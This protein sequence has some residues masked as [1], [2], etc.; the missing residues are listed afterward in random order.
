MKICMSSILSFL[1]P[2]AG[3]G[4]IIIHH[5]ANGLSRLGHEVYVIY[6]TRKAVRAVV[7]EARYKII[8]ARHFE[9]RSLNMLSVF[10]AFFR[11][12]R[13]AAFS[14]FLG[15]S[16]EALLVNIF[17]KNRK[18]KLLMAYFN[19]HPPRLY[20]PAGLRLLFSKRFFYL[21]RACLALADSVIAISRD[22][23]RRIS[24]N[25]NIPLRK[26]EVVY[27]GVDIEVFSRQA[28]G[29]PAEKGR[30]VTVGRLDDQKGIDVL[31]K[32]VSLVSRGREIT[33][34]IVGDGWM[35][36]RYEKIASELA[37]SDRV[38]FVGRIQQE[39]IPDYLKRASIFVL[40]SRNESFGLVLVEAMASGIPVISTNVGSIPEIVRDG[41][42]GILVEPGDA[43]MLAS[44]IQDLLDDRGKTKRFTEQARQRVLEN[45]TWEKSVERLDAVYKRN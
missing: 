8:W 6:T 26:I 30:L 44:A 12:R 24:E 17:F 19:P 21:E 25:F 32:A 13:K 27:C 1:E 20:N 16:A 28:E 10:F 39:Q 5:W 41:E 38:N 22:S 18:I 23:G 35:R 2:D 4:Q 3:G 45:F 43:D 36:K 29:R 31:L 40:A 7:P 37:I 15:T 9:N 11:H 42:T 33:L 14:V 34:D